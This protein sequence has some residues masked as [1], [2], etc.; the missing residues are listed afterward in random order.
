MPP[1]NEHTFSIFNSNAAKQTNQSNDVHAYSS[2]RSML[3]SIVIIYLCI[4][5]VLWYKRIQSRKMRSES[6]PYSLTRFFF[7]FDCVEILLRVNKKKN[8]MVSTNALAK[9][10]CK[11]NTCAVLYF[12]VVYFVVCVWDWSQNKTD[13]TQF[14][15]TPPQRI[16]VWNVYNTI[17]VKINR[18]EHIKIRC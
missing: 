1:W 4:Y 17:S 6:L 8:I 10:R 14:T 16:V 2:I 13:P 9:Y 7:P 3:F 15:D 12:R 5:V 11:L 18:K